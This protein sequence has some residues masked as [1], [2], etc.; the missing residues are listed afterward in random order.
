MVEIDIEIET[1]SI[2]DSKLEEDKDDTS[3]AEIPKQTFHV[4]SLKVEWEGSS[5]FMHVFIETTNIVNLE[6]AKNN[7]K[8]QK[9]MFA[10]ASHEFRTP[11]NAIM[12]SYQFIDNSFNTVVETF[13]TEEMQ[14]NSKKV[15]NYNSEKIQKFLKM[16]KNSS[17]LLLALIEDILDLSKMEAGTFRINNA[18]FQ[19]PDLIEGIH[20][21][22]NV[23]CQQ[24][25]I[26]LHFDVPDDLE[27]QTIYSDES[28]IKQIL[29]NLMSNAVK[30]T[31]SGSITI[32]MSIEIKK[33]MKVLVIRVKDTGL[34]IKEK[35]KSKLFHLFGMISETKEINPNGSGI[36]LT[37]CRKYV[38]KLGGE[39]SLESEFG[40]GTSVTFWVPVI[41]PQESPSS[42]KS[43]QM[44]AMTE[45]VAAH[46]EGIGQLM[47]HKVSIF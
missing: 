43:C 26:K 36:G 44:L 1:N 9:I 15:V 27:Q 17:I 38:E 4:K 19:T 11:L 24:K 13:K 39:I 41:A 47:M 21:I 25:K 45:P 12:N 34:G 28:R 29:L 10:S 22:F 23:Q 37:I 42:K 2:D 16:G 30:F 31:F 32:S 8:C 46:G 20:D 18:E 6:K 35:D 7:I 3:D 14:P 5:S 40:E 33:N